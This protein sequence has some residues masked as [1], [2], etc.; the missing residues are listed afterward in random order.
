MKFHEN[1]FSPN[2]VF[3]RLNE[4]NNSYTKKY[5]HTTAVTTID[6]KM[7][8]VPRCRL[9]CLECVSTCLYF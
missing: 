3:D 7:V 9:E 4:S 1:P 6:Y 5:F 8:Q 2:R